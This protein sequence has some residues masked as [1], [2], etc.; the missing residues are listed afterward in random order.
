MLARSFSTQRSCFWSSQFWTSFPREHPFVIRTQLRHTGKRTASRSGSTLTD[1][2][3][4]IDAYPDKE[5][6]Y[7][8]DD[9][10]T[11]SYPGL[12]NDR[13]VGAFRWFDRWRQD[14]E[15]GNRA[16][17]ENFKSEWWNLAMSSEMR[18]GFQLQYLY[19][20]RYPSSWSVSIVVRFEVLVLEPP[21]G[22]IRQW[23]LT[24]LWSKIYRLFAQIR[25]FW[26]GCKWCQMPDNKIL[27]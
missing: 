6:D 4:E 5:T 15:G 16:P 8:E 14:W 25:A 18:K 3:L 9:E 21:L 1:I 19:F 27:I 26:N 13:E 22:R 10:G 24:L 17:A 23:P 12:F 7:E 20:S 2:S 11:N